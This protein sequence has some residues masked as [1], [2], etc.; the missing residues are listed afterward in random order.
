MGQ[1]RLKLTEL[2]GLHPLLG[3]FVDGE[4]IGGPFL[5]EYDVDDPADMGIEEWF[6]LS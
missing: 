3:H 1:A 4:L 5:N 6:N 2:K